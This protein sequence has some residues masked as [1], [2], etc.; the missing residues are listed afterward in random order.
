MTE[1]I[2]LGSGQLYIAPYVA[3]TGIPDDAALETDTYLLGR[4][5]GGAAVEYKPSEYE[6]FDDAY[7]VHNRY[8]ISEEV[9]FKS[10][11][12][13]WNVATLK[14]LI[15]K[16]TYA[17]T[18][19]DGKRTLSLGGKGARKMDEY[20][21]RFVHTYSDTNKLRVTMVATAS[22]GFNLAFAPDKETVIDAQFKA[23]ATGAAGVQ[24]I[25][26]DTYG[27]GTVYTVTNTL[28]EGI[29]NSNT[30]TTA[31]KS[32]AYNALISA[33]NGVA[34]GVVAVTMAT[35]DITTA[36]FTAA[37]GVVAIPEVTGNIVITAAAVA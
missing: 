6:I 13:T 3:A 26:Q 34:V 5:K 4:I 21:V 17:D 35:T 12:L 2:V 15:A 31:A 29:L 36:A 16:G 19:A 24:L 14:N 23:K 33:I 27:E 32:S 30:A 20:V 1:N 18:P 11:I 7:A 25:I 10:G 8:V 28:A 22:N 9:T 37:T